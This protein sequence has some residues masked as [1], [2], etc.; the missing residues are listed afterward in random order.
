M[1]WGEEKDLLLD[2]NIFSKNILLAYP[3]P[4]FPVPAQASKA[5]QHIL[6]CSV[7][8]HPRQPP[9]PCSWQAGQPASAKPGRYFFQKRH[10]APWQLHKQLCWQ[11]RLAGVCRVF[12]LPPRTLSHRHEVLSSR[13]SRPFF[14]PHQGGGGGKLRAPEIFA[15]GL[16]RPH[17]GILCCQ[18]DFAQ[19]AQPSRMGHGTHSH[20]CSPICPSCLTYA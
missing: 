13:L 5:Q 20:Q 2:Q 14:T 9:P 10:L 3:G 7:A 18:V 1:G 4:P 15:P 8:A 17:L 6:G 11:P 16:R 19:V 12:R